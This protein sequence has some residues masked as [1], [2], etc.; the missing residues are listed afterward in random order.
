MLVVVVEDTKEAV[1]VAVVQAAAALVQQ[2]QMV[3]V[4]EVQHNLVLVEMVFLPI[5]LGAAQLEQAKI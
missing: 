4:Q 1:M 2:V 3:L 5:L